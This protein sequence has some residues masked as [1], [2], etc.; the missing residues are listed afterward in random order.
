MAVSVWGPET[1]NAW[2]AGEQLEGDWTQSQTLQIP[3]WV[4][5][6]DSGSLWSAALT[7]AAFTVTNEQQICDLHHVNVSGFGKKQLLIFYI[8]ATDATLILKSFW[9]TET[10][11]HTH[12]EKNRKVTLYFKV[13]L[14]HVTF[15][16]YYNNN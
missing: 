4:P 10:E 12:R 3:V 13:S 1:P 8:H 11:L 16:Y 9:K 7:S 14:L 6:T 15:T 2:D 5:D